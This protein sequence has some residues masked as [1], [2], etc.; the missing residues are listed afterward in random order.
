MKKWIIGTLV[1]LVIIIAAAI[2]SS[3]SGTVT[4]NPP[5]ADSST[6]SNQSST[7]QSTIEPKIDPIIVEASELV[8]EYDKNKLAAQDKYTGKLVQI[9]GYIKNISNDILNNYYLA[10]DPVKKEYYFGTT[11]QC[12]FEDKSELTTLENGQSVT[13]QGTMDDMSVGTVILKE[14]QLTK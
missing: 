9:T 5:T 7:P 4:T 12:Y 1:V 11:I 8:G 14:C 10:L 13:V 2:S 6:V 3:K